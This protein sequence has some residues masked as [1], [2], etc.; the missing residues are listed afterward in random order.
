MYFIDAAFFLAL[1]VICHEPIKKA[2]NVIKEF[3]DKE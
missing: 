1:G 3:L 2:Y